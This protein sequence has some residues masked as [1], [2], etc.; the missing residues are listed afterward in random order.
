[1][2]P[3]ENV[4]SAMLLSFVIDL[5]LQ[6]VDSDAIIN[7]I[8]NKMHGFGDI[9]YITGIFNKIYYSVRGNYSNGKNHYFDIE[10]RK[11]DSKIEA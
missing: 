3:I 5:D 7:F 11:H 1:M 4:F 6:I 10:K 2:Y 8:C 9:Y